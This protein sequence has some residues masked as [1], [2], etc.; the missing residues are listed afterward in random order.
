VALGGVVDEVDKATHSDKLIR[1]AAAASEKKGKQLDLDVVVPVRE[2]KRQEKQDEDS[3]DSED[4]RRRE[5]E[6]ERRDAKKYLKRKEAVIEELVPKATGK[7]A[8]LEKKKKESAYHRSAGDD[9]QADLEA[10]D[11]YGEGPSIKARI[12]RDRQMR[13]KQ[14]DAKVETY[15]K[16]LADYK[17]RSCIVSVWT[18]RRSAGKGGR[19]DGAVYCHARE[20]RLRRFL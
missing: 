6:E 11:P 12:A 14:A 16:A 9:A 13:Q 7:D 1:V 17:V 19:Q 2:N 3:E 8:Q 15:H 4:R 10:F 5:R 20:R 18:H